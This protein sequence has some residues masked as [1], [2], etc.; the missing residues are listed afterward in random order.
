M[1]VEREV[2]LHQNTAV[3]RKIFSKDDPLGE[4]DEDTELAESIED[5]LLQDKG[6]NGILHHSPVAER[7]TN[8]AHALIR[9]LYVSYTLGDPKCFDNGGIKRTVYVL[10]SRFKPAKVFCKAYSI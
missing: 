6:D 8:L 7:G 10:Y 2:I 4:G 5:G 9:A 3:N 1:Y